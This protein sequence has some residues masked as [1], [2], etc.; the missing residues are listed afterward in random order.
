MNVPLVMLLIY[1]HS[2]TNRVKYTFNFIF[3]SILGI[4]FELTTDIDVFKQFNGAK[5][6]YTLKQIAD[7]IF[8]QSSGLLFGSGISSSPLTSFKIEHGIENVDDIFSF[9]FFL[10]TRYEE[11]LPFTGDKYGRFSAKQSFAYK[12]G[13]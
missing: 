13:F 7:E 12:N 5:I 4:D 1:T 9:A 3:K 10:V 2:I 6:S 8:F 11:Y